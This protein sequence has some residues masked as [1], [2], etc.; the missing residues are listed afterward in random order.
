MWRAVHWA[1]RISNKISVAACVVKR[2][3]S[4]K[5]PQ[6]VDLA[7]VPLSKFK[8]L[9]LRVAFAQNVFYIILCAFR[10]SSAFLFKTPPLENLTALT[11]LMFIQA[12]MGLSFPSYI[13]AYN[14]S[15]LV[16]FMNHL[17]LS[18]IWI[19]IR[20]KYF[21]YFSQHKWNQL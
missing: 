18:P 10:L 6:L 20:S 12:L 7:P 3:T 21:I 8:I 5:A 16:N 2:S 17:S 9:R 15:T 13:M 4:S 19:R 11:L 1:L 14:A